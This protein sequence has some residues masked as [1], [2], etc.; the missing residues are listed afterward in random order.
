M[1]VAVSCIVCHVVLQHFWLYEHF[2]LCGLFPWHRK[3]KHAGRNFLQWRQ[4]I[5][6]NHA[7]LCSICSVRKGLNVSFVDIRHI[8]KKSNCMETTKYHGCVL[9]NINKVR[10]FSVCD[11]QC[12]LFLKCDHFMHR[13][14]KWSQQ[15]QENSHNFHPILVA[16]QHWRKNCVLRNQKQNNRG[17]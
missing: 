3:K 2:W 14:R 4:V 17:T 7:V 9:D 13:C 6:K 11:M 15:N 16:R 5:L 12:H 10:M 1:C 8:G